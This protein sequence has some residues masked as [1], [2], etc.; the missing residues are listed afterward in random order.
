MEQVTGTVTHYTV[1]HYVVKESTCQVQEQFF[2][3]LR[4]IQSRVDAAHVWLRSATVSEA[5]LMCLK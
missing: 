1:V 2:K 4:Q 5:L 3:V